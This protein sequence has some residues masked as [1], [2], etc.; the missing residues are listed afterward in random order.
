MPRT[1]RLDLPELLQHVMVI[2][3]DRKDVS[4]TTPIKP[5]PHPLPTSTPQ[6]GAPDQLSLRACLETREPTAKAVELAPVRAVQIFQGSG[7]VEE[8]NHPDAD[9]CRGQA[10]E[11]NPSQKG[12]FLFVIWFP[13]TPN[14]QREPSRASRII[15]SSVK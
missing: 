10:D 13:V 15:K 8:D 7:Q 6:D 14:S 12:P 9:G 1:A 5:R 2:R 3:I 4:P 11:V